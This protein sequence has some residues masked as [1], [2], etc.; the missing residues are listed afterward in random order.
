MILDP[1]EVFCGGRVGVAQ[2]VGLREGEGDCR[3]RRG[4]LLSNVTW[5]YTRSLIHVHMPL[6]IVSRTLARSTKP[7]LSHSLVSHHL[8]PGSGEG[9]VP[10]C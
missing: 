10:E 3:D 5:T 9:G 4:V 7:A 1:V 8:A 2:F 6:L